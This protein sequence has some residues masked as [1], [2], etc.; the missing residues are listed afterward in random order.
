MR[1]TASSAASSGSPND[2]PITNGT[3]SNGRNRLVEI[4]SG[5]DLGGTVYYQLTPNDA[6]K[7][8]YIRNSL[9]T[10]DLIVFQGTYNASND[11]LIP[12]G[13]TAV[14]FFNGTGSGAVA[15]NVM[16][17][18]HFDA[19]NIVGNAVVGG[20]LDV[21]SVATA[22]TFEPDGDTA[23]GDNAAIG[24]TAAEGLILTGQ[25]STNDVTIK[26]DAD[27][28]VLEIPTGTTNVTIAGNLGVGGTVTGTGT[29]VFASL[30]I[31]GDIDV[32]GTTNLDVV[33]IDGAVDMASTLTVG[34][35]ISL[36]GATTI[37]NTSGNLTFDVVGDIILDADDGDIQFKN[38]G[39]LFGSIN[40]DASSPQA[41]RMQA[42]VSDGDIVFK[43]NDGGSTITAL[44]LDMSEAGAATFNSSVIIPQKLIHS[45]DTDTYLEF[46]TNQI[47]LIVGNA[48][49][50]KSS[51]SEVIINEAS[52][53]IDFRVESNSNANMLFVDAGNDHVNIGSSTDRGGLLN[54]DG[55]TK[56]IV[57][58]TTNSAA[59]ELIHADNGAGTGPIMYLNR[60]S[61]G[62]AADDQLGR[63][64]VQGKNS[65]DE[66]IDYVRLINQ[67]LS[68][69]DGV[70]EQGRFAINT[71][72]SGTQ[73]SRLNIVSGESVFNDE[74]VNVD[75]RVESNNNANMLFVDGGTDRIGIGT[76]SPSTF[77]HAQSSGDIQFRFETT[78]DSTAQIQYKNGNNQWSAGIDNLEQ[79]FVYDSTNAH[80]ALT[81]I[82][83][84]SVVF[85]QNSKDVDFRIESD[86][87]ANMLRVDA[88][89][90]I[91]G[92]GMA[93]DTDVMLSVNGAVGTTNGSASSPTHTFY[94][95]P[96]TGMFRR[97]SDQ[98][99][100]SAG[101]TE[102]V[103][104]TSTGIFADLVGAKTTNANLSLKASGTG[105]V[106]V[107]QDGADQDFRVESDSNAN[108]LTVDAGEDRVLIGTSGVLGKMTSAPLQVGGFG[109]RTMGVSSSATDTGISVN[110]GSTG[111]GMLV[112][113][114]RNTSN[115]TATASGLYLLNFYHD[116][117]HTPAV[118]HIS[119]TN[120]LA[121]SKSGSN[122]LTIQNASGGNCTCTM[123]MNG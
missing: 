62:P 108:M 51:A 1:I 83:L 73:N 102:S 63:I 9:N 117:D 6:E 107:N 67:L 24:Y 76:S 41:M 69:T 122:T 112:L 50:F 10:Q 52:A 86:N 74:S 34:G 45:G 8:I 121:F 48:A 88:G 56:G 98:L 109:I 35:N 13:K 111:M 3:A 28:D 59:M 99:G 61:S 47:D 65:A 4:Y 53:D 106:V 31:S 20:T 104:V 90:D 85:N 49:T 87:N 36:T 89:N 64:V 22:T 110:A 27:A 66:V 58:R 25:G 75:F 29:S 120:Y 103:A 16:S 92:V 118:S 37:S 113:T 12:N 79:F 15:A 115:G 18:A 81:F 5:T 23:A 78:S 21:T 57:V 100:F 44:Q 30:D 38:G 68:P 93:P 40:S 80:S 42:H 71:M 82:P 119:G 91:L 84:N 17:N 33:D 77:M 95:D 43:G 101:G 32:D 116:G 114:S 96:D 70:S 72:T 11:Y 94:S 97:G 54:V 60:P 105:S 19:L 55:T 7:I 2:L 123:M 26:N 46:T 39:T 14:I